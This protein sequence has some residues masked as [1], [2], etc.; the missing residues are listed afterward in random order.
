MAWA[1]SHVPARVENTRAAEH[2]E[3]QKGKEVG[4]TRARE[5]EKEEESG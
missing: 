1:F 4:R 3:A 5:K 2:R